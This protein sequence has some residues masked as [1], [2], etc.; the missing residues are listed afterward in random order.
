MMENMEKAK[1]THSTK[2]SLAENTSNKYPKIDQPNSSTQAQK[3]WI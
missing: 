1:G 2:I 3:F